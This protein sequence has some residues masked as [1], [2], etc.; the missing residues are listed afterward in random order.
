MS[1][2]FAEFVVFKE[3]SG[4][5]HTFNLE[6]EILLNIELLVLSKE[7]RSELVLHFTERTLEGWK[8]GILSITACYFFHFVI[9][10]AS[11]LDR[12]TEGRKSH[13]SA[14]LRVDLAFVKSTVSFSQ[15]I[16]MG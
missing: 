7:G 5:F 15:I 16:E 1:K 6:D 4:L 2:P 8:F 11:Q 14:L 9:I 13:K 3:E 10:N 12:S